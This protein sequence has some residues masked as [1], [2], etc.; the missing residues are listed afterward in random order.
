MNKKK[1]ILVALFPIVLLG[2]WYFFIKDYNYKIT[3]KTHQAPGIVYHH[4]L[5]WNDG[6][7]KN[8]EVI[9]LIEKHPFNR[10]NQEFKSG[11]AT[12]NLNWEIIKE[13]DTTSFV[14][15]KIK[16]ES[17]SF[18][19]NLQAIFFKNDFVKNRISKVKDLRSYIN[20]KAEFYRI[21]RI[22][23][24]I[25]PSVNCAYITLESNIT[26]KAM[27]MV[28]NIS[29]V[30]SYIKD[31][32]I[33]LTGNPFSE[34]TSWNMDNDSIKFN[35]CFPIKE[36][37]KYPESDIVKIKKS[38][39]KSGIKVDYNGNYSTSHL[40]WYRLLDYAKT[41][42]ININNLPIEIYKND[43]HLGGDA[44]KWLAEIY[45]PIEP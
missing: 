38:I 11:D 8:I 30:M 15:L 18:K 41:Y 34:I 43:P 7:A 12:Y 29:L 16:D 22:T 32:D 2:I 36:M 26:N 35:F 24:D 40:A 1:I 21:S 17:N 10:I 13:N 42:N 44:I 31:N 6:E 37:E 19:Q 25:L 33:E 39:P 9:N 3:F 14:T 45:M 23:K 28:S 4:I 20:N 5:E 27:S